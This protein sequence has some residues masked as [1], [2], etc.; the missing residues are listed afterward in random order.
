MKV[1]GLSVAARLEASSPGR[2]GCVVTGFGVNRV[3]RY[4]VLGLAR[5]H[6]EPPQRSQN[7]RGPK[8]QG[9]VL[10]YGKWTGD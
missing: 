1:W 10:V 9:E 8:D 7:S 5:K 2:H 3:L 4:K 6:S